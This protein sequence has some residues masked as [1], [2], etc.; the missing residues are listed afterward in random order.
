MT[1]AGARA[2]ATDLTALSNGE[3]VEILRSRMAHLVSVSDYPHTKESGSLPHF[4]ERCSHTEGKESFERSMLEVL[5][6]QGPLGELTSL[7]G[8]PRGAATSIADCPTA[9]VHIIAQVTAAGKHV[10]VI[11]LSDLLW[12]AVS[13]AGG[14]LSLIAVVDCP[15]ATGDAD[16]N[17]PDPLSVLGVLCEGMDLVIYCGQGQAD[18]PPSLARPVMSRVRSSRC[19]L[20]VC[21]VRWPGVSLR[22]DATVSAFRGLGRGRGRIR[23]M[24]VDMRVVDRHRPPQ[25]GQWHMGVGSFAQPIRHHRPT[26]THHWRKN[27]KALD[28]NAVE[29]AG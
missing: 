4:S 2:V 3:K 20:L 29:A 26:Q 16:I 22:I 10:A 27:V 14:D 6:L 19:V 21:G 5:S 9:L 12:A 7:G 15:D 23:G 28:L 17:A 13:D 8:L 18:V 11:G 25:R 24:S 1:Q